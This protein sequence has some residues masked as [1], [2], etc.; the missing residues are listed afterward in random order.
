MTYPTLSIF[1]IAF[2]RAMLVHRRVTFSLGLVL[3]LFA[4]KKIYMWSH[5]IYKI[6]CYISKSVLT[7]KTRCLSTQMICLARVSE[8]ETRH[9]HLQN[10]TCSNATT[11][12][13]LHKLMHMFHSNFTVPKFNI[14]PEKIPSQWES[15]LPTIIFQGTSCWTSGGYLSEVFFSPPL[16]NIKNKR[17]DLPWPTKTNPIGSMWLLYL[18]TTNFICTIQKLNH[19]GLHIQ[20]LPWIL[21][22][23]NSPLHHD[24]SHRIGKAKLRMPRWWWTSKWHRRTIDA[25]IDPRNVRMKHQADGL[26]QIGIT[27]IIM[28]TMKSE[29]RWPGK[30]K[31]TF[32]KSNGYS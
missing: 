26:W 15:S 21:Y 24:L 12:L 30:K 7:P 17:C 10:V 8:T 9:R 3:P 5:R 25:V 6:I 13:F 28:I 4:W 14:A 23:Y 20:N 1:Q 19:S 32:S 31:K 27:K 22:I 29:S 11:F 18:P 16:R 2:W